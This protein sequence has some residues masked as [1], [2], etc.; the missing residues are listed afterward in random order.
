MSFDVFDKIRSACSAVA[1]RASRV[2]INTEA[3]PAYAVSLPIEEIQLP[4]LDP[5]SH[6]LG[7]GEDTAAFLITL[8]TINFG[9]GYFPHLQKRPGCSGYFTVAHALNDLF[10]RRGPVPAD[11]LSQLSAEH[12]AEIFGQDAANPDAFELMKLF[13]IALNDLGRFLRERFNGSF[14]ELIRS[15]DA[16]ADA[17]VRLLAEMPFFY[18]VETYDR[19]EVPFFKRAQIVAS[20]LALAFDGR[21]LGT[22]HDLDR[23]TIFA[24]NL[25][26]HVL[27]TDEIL[28]YEKALRAGIDAGMLIPAGSR[29]EIEIR[30]CALQAVENI[31]NELNRQGHAVSAYQLDYLLW[32]R[33]QQPYYKARPRHRTRTVFY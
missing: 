31:K 10:N 33:G 16:S 32:N 17:M 22:F 4:D 28:V 13:A 8:D 12:C 24:D 1:D 20:D 23:L 27:R 21:G 18:D 7:R 3:I 26:P 9:S 2:R 25:V 29:E 19:L 14:V 15:V 30:A 5:G 11:E 6:Y